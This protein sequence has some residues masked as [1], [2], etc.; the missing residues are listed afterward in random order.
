[1]GDVRLSSLGDVVVPQQYIERF[2]YFHS[3]LNE[4]LERGCLFVDDGTGFLGQVTWPDEAG[5][6][7]I[8]SPL[9]PVLMRSR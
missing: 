4:K 5:I 2:A 1:M 6:R 7:E 3:K 9:G 8:I